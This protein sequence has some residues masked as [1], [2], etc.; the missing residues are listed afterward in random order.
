MR[1]HIV[2]EGSKTT[3]DSR[4][5]PAKQYYQGLFGMVAGLHDELSDFAE[6]D[7]HILSEDYGVVG[8]EEIVSSVS[9]NVSVSLGGNELTSRAKDEILGIATDADV[10]VILL[11]TAVFQV[12]VGEVW[13][14]LVEAAKPGS[15]WCLGAARSTLDELHFEGLEAKGCSVI[16]YRRVGVARI[17]DDT[18]SELL[19]TVK[20]KA[21]L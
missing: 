7:L 13:D 1:A 17:S 5:L 16:T 19:D 11:S 10:M 9:E 6:A 12:T 18:R 4:D 2:A 21:E 14:E 8:G 3:A 20:R 15:I